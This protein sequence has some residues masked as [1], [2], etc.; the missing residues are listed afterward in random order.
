[1]PLL[2]SA[3]SPNVSV[4]EGVWEG[5]EEGKKGKERLGNISIGIEG[6]KKR[7]KKR[8][9]GKERETERLAKI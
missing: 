7:E 8:V 4:R 2:A 1:M 3:T 5:R 6:K 9:R